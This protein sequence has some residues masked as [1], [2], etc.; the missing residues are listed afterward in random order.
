MRDDLFE[1][2]AHREIVD[3]ALVVI[4]VAAGQ[5]RPIQVP[6]EHLLV[7]RQVGEAVGVELHDGGFIDL[8]QAVRA[9]ARRRRYRARRGQIS[10]SDTST[11][12]PCAG[13]CTPHPKVRSMVLFNAFWA[14]GSPCTR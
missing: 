8:F 9:I 7:Q 6:Y 2:V 3:I 13:M 10:H 12:S 11:R 14:A 5:R 1:D 4:D